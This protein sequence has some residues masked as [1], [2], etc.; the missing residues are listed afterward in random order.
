M[1]H[2]ILHARDLIFAAVVA[3]ALAITAARAPVVAP[4]PAVPASP[5]NYAT[6]AEDVPAP[7]IPEEGQGVD[8]IDHAA[9]W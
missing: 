5:P 7:G 6:S 8:E 1:L 9:N 2:H 3:V 4:A